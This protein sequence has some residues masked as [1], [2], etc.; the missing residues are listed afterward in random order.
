MA[1]SIKQRRIADQ[2]GLG[3]KRETISKI[4]TAKRARGLAE[5]VECLLGKHETQRSNSP[6]PSPVPTNK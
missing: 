6:P 5:V 1:G 4:T 3:K 2:A